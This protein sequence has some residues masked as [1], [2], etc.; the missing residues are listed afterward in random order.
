MVF[1]TLSFR[2]IGRFPVKLIPGDAYIG[3]K[4]TAY[5]VAQPKAQLCVS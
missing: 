1:L 2:H 5:F 4:L 3:C